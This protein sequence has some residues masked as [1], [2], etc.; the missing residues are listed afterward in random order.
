M[1]ED[2]YKTLGID[3]KAS[4][5]E[6]KS[7]Y[8][9][10]AKKYHPDRNEGKKSAEDKFK[11]VSEAYA[12]LSDPKKRKNYDMFGSEKFHQKYSQDDIFRGTNINDILRDFGLGDIFGGGFGRGGG[13]SAGRAGRS[14]F[15]GG[16]DP[17]GGGFGHQ[18]VNLDVTSQLDISLEESVKGGERQISFQTGGKNE[19]VNVKIPAGIQNGGKLRLPGKGNLHQNRRGDLFIEVRINHHP[20]IKREK[21]DLIIQKEIELTTGLLG[22]PLEVETFDGPKKIKAPAGTRPGQKIRIKGGGVKSM[23]TGK[24][25]DLYIEIGYQIPK[26]LTKEQKELLAKLQSTGL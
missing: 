15:G 6:I 24:K 19:S 2:Y 23:K 5:G 10:L 8:R 14:R 26:K 11:K 20:T 18:M 13:A 25:G 1:A 16:G 3:K 9:K 4:A 12:V 21:D 17:F 22:G 7:A